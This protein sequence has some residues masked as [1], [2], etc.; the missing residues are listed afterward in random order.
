[1][2]MRLRLSVVLNLFLAGGLVFLALGKHSA[3]VPSPASESKTPVPV[4]ASSL[5][6]QPDT[7]PQPFRWQQLNSGN[8][9]RLFIANLRA[10][11]C[12]ENTIEDIVRGNV[13]RAFAWERSRQKMDG[14]GPWPEASETALVNNLMGK[15]STA[16]SLQNAD[17]RLAN[18]QPVQ[19]SN[20]QPNPILENTQSGQGN[21]NRLAENASSVQ[22]FYP[23]VSQ[24]GN[25]GTAGSL[26]SGSSA[27]E[28][29]QKSGGLTQ[30]PAL[31]EPQ[32]NI[33]ANGSPM[34]SSSGGNPSP[35]QNVSATANTP[36]GPPDPLGPNDPYARSAQ[37]IMNQDTSVYDNW[38][39][40]QMAA[41]A[42][43]DTPGINLGSAPE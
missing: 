35:G 12:P 41:Q 24:R 9:Y 19:A 40:Q 7:Q 31:V 5:P 21:D 34:D 42:G 15:P 11:G 8:D 28:P 38:F 30:P 27:V 18:Q 26:S 23:W 39:N 10:A 13:S 25:N 2:K 1:M 17:H 20:E 4:A 43:S 16:V 6:P 32:N 3:V 29:G 37:D 36:T 22:Q 14:L 33:Q